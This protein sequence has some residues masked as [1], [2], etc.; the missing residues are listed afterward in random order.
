VCDWWVDEWMAL[1]KQHCRQC[2]V[3]Q[4][5]GDVGGGRQKKEKREISLKIVP[6]DSGKVPHT[7]KVQKL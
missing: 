3:T 6:D 4:V 7:N 1:S 2:C 5:V